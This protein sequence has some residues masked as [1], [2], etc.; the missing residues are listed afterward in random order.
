[1]AGAG[2]EGVGSD[3]PP[4][5]QIAVGLYGADAVLVLRVLVSHL[6]RTGKEI[7]LGVAAVLAL[8]VDPMLLRCCKRPRW[9]RRQ[10][11]VDLD[12]RG[13]TQPQ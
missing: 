9:G 4:L 12:V 8:V 1:M 6:G 10:P 5:T 11:Q 13:I 2:A 7:G 3:A